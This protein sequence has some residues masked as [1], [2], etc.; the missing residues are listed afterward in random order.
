MSIK[1]RQ[2]KLVKG[3]TYYLDI[4][5]QGKRSY[6]TLFKVL[7]SD[8]KKL[9]RDLAKSILR[10]RENELFNNGSNFNKFKNLMTLEYLNCYLE[11]YDKKDFNTMKASIKHFNHFIEGKD[12]KLTYLTSSHLERFYNY[13]ENIGLK[14][15]TPK[16]YYR[17]LRK[18]FNTAVKEGIISER[19]L[20]NVTIKS[21]TIESSISLKK[22]VL[23]EIEINK[24]INTECGNNEVKRAFLFACYSGLGLAELY[25]LKL[26]NIN[27]GRLR[28]FRKKSGIEVNIKLS[29]SAISLIDFNSNS[30][31]IF[32]LKNKN[33]NRKLTETGINKV[34]YNLMKRANIN[35]K[36]TFYCARHTFAIRLL[37]NG[38]NI[39]V[40]SD[41]LGHRSLVNTY[42]YLNYVDDLKDDA[43]SNLK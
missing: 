38:A 14:G 9:K 39:K 30:E 28:V 43:T 12:F 42:K 25:D 23:T 10:E 31:F 2:K 40:V 8:D 11:L 21:K 27:N 33:T 37:K 17:R 6:E 24:V 29:N 34:L 35:K 15:D 5:F 22:E 18:A 4:Y 1:L 3:F 26:S 7:P 16:T 41:A 13:L 32:D 20:K 19:I 36:I